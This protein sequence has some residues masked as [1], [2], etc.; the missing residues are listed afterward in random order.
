ML[1]YIKPSKANG[2]ITAPPSKSVAHR[3]LICAALSD[4]C[5][6][7]NIEQSDDITATLCALEAL[8]ANTRVSENKV[9]LGGLSVAGITDTVINANESGSTLRFILPLCMISGK[10]IKFT[11]AKR[12]FARDLSVY[13]EIAKSNGF[14]F[15]LNEDSLTVNG[16]LTAGI[17]CIRG[18]ISSQFVSG[19]LFALPLLDGD[20]EIEFSTP[21][22]SKPYIDLTVNVLSGFGIR[23]AETENGY[24]VK[25]NQRYK[26]NDLYVEGDCSNAA[27]LEAF[28]LFGGNVTVAGL[29]PNTVQG[30]R[31]Y[32]EIFSTLKSGGC[33]D[34]QNCPDLAPLL[35]ALAAAFS[36]ARFTGT[37]R[38]KIKE[39]DRA[40]AMKTELEKFGADISVADNEVYINKSELHAPG[41]VLDSHNDHRVVMA[42][43]VL[44][45]VYGG[46]I[47]GVQSV[48]KSYPG[49][50]D[51]LKNLG[52]GVEIID[53]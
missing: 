18:D 12:L 34:L 7:S 35:F 32:K 50:F 37:A 10:R 27:P 44:L 24:F 16:R 15:S 5:E 48:K 36:G 30:D 51:D 39:S 22:Q 6:I 17:Y 8:G 46:S 49:F 29:N 3:A 31:V 28:N 4:G 20:S 1:V 14:E 45:S 26:A 38:L 42:L 40:N 21:V 9:T 52:I 47:T 25:G 13:G 19:L 53:D 2:T 11:G 43:S 41:C 33:Y 23:I